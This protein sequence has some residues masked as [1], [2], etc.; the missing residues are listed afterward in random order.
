MIYNICTASFVLHKFSGYFRLEFTRLYWGSIHFDPHFCF[1]SNISSLGSFP[2]APYPGPP[3]RGGN[4]G[5]GMQQLGGRGGFHPHFNGPPRGYQP[6]TRHAHGPPIVG[7]PQQRG[8]MRGGGMPHMSRGMPQQR[9]RGGMRGGMPQ[10]R[11]PPIVGMDQGMHQLPRGFGGPYRGGG[12][13]A[14]DNW[15]T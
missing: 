9:G 5:R 3:A 14:S 13:K 2:P 1:S 7:M 10:Q 11:G 4:P 8:G 12:G 15:K 6:V